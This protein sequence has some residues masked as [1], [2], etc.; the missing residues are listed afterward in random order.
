MTR[1][2]IILTGVLAL[3][4][5]GNGHAQDETANRASG[6]RS[7]LASATSAQQPNRWLPGFAE[8][9][10]GLQARW[11]LVSLSERAGPTSPAELSSLPESSPRERPS[12][13]TE[14]LPDSADSALPRLIEEPDTAQ[15]PQRLPDV[16]GHQAQ[17]EVELKASAAPLQTTTPDEG[18][19]AQFAASQTPYAALGARLADDELTFDARTLDPTQDTLRSH[20]SHVWQSNGLDDVLMSVAAGVAEGWTLSESQRASLNPQL[21]NLSLGRLYEG[22]EPRS[23]ETQRPWESWV[24]IFKASQQF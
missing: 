18:R 16:A 11:T 13:S 9:L 2:I 8:P 1:H 12:A 22:R 4:L 14:G 10:T 3:A 6:G 5:I 20:L 24:V 7:D 17:E 15:D 23:E 21:E 19:I